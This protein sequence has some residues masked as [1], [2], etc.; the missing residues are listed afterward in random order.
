[1]SRRFYKSA[2]A[3]A[4]LFLPLCV[5][6]AE[7]TTTSMGALTLQVALD[8]AGFSPGVI[9]G[10]T[11]RLTEQAVRG[12]QEA[13]G[14]SVTGKVDAET[15]AALGAPASGTEMVAVTDEDAAGPFVETIPEKMEEKAKLAALH[16]TSI[17]EALAEKY[18]T[19]PAKLREL[20][21]DATFE[22]GSMITVP[23]VRPAESAVPVLPRRVMNTPP[24]NAPRAQRVN[25]PAQRPQVGT[26]TARPRDAGVPMANTTPR[27]AAAPQAP[28]D[29]NATAWDK[30]LRQLS[31]SKVQPAAAKLVVDKSDKHVRVLDGMGKVLAQFPATMGS[32]HDPLPIGEWQ[33]RGVSR[34]PTFNYNPDLFWDAEP[35]DKK[36]KL[37]PG[38]NGPVGVVWLD[39]SKEHYGIHGTPEPQTISRTASHGCI[40]LTNWDAAK[41][42]QMVK[43]GTPATLQE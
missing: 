8:R 17:E 36:A 39:L 11:G 15:E 28:P 21:P 10:R 4:L 37:P 33:I 18:H 23:A 12:F 2:C 22:P 20:N 19:T 40:R 14:L 34:L 38:P 30:T 3:A 7:S 27:V 35:G 43:P 16:Y 9:D 42:A 6:A 29:E 5:Q 31:V 13:N 32:E 1:M 26:N 24:P 41:L 25:A